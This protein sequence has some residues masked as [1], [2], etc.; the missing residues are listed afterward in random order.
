MRRPK[1]T[2]LYL[3]I[4]QAMISVPPVLPLLM[5]TIPI[6]KPNIPAPITVAMNSCPGP[7]NNGKLPAS[8]FITIWKNQRRKVRTGIAYRVFIQNLGP[9]IFNANTIK[10]ALM[11]K[12]ET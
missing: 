7:N 10:M 12:Y 2:S 9:R 1:V 8:S 4:I 3:L 5:K 11:I 6:P